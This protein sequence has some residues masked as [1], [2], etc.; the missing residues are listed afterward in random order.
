MRASAVVK[1]QSVGRASALRRSGQAAV[2]TLAA[3]HAELDLGHIQPGAVL[4]GVVDRQ[5]IGQPPGLGGRE[6]FVERGG[7]AGV[8]VGHDPHDTRRVGI[9]DVRQRLDLPLLVDAGPALGRIRPALA[10]P[11]WQG[12]GVDVEHILH[13]S[14][15]R[16]VGLRRDAPGTPAPAA[17]SAAGST[18]GAPPPAPP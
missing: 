14:G 1:H 2:E 16:G 17:H 15:E 13:V 12:A 18:P 4:G 3:Q 7:A 8:A 5:L 9:A 6:G 10:G 11:G